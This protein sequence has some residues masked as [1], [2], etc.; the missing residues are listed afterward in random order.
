MNKKKILIFI[1][2]LFSVAFILRLGVA[3][4]MGVNHPME[5][6]AF[7]YLQLA[8][9]LVQGTGY[10]VHDSFWPDQPTMQRMP[11]WPFL[12]SV[13]LRV[14]PWFSPDFV[15]RILCILMDSLNAVL[16]GWLTWRLLWTKVSP[17][18]EARVVAAVSAAPSPV[19]VHDSPGAERK[20]AAGDSRYYTEEAMP[21][22]VSLLAGLIY[23]A[24][25]A[26]L[27]LVYNGESEPLFIMLCLSG[28][29]LLLR[30]GRWV[31]LASLCFGLSC[32]IRANYV[33]WLGVVGGFVVMRWLWAKSAAEDPST[34]FKAGSRSY[35]KREDNRSEA[36]VVAGVPTGTCEKS[37]A[38]TAATTAGK[39]GGMEHGVSTHGRLIPMV[40]LSLLFLAPSLFW[41]TRNYQVCGHFPVLSTLRGQ[42]FYG[43]NNSVVANTMDLWGYWIFPDGVPGEKKAAELA[44]TMTEY[45]LDVYYFNKGKEYVK[46][47]WFAIPRLLLGKF[48]RA[49]VPIPWKPNILSYGVGAYRVVIY[50]LAIAG[51]IWWWRGQREDNGSEARVVTAE[52]G[53]YAESQ[54]KVYGLKAMVSLVFLSMLLTN[55]AGVLIFWGCFRF[56][57]V[58][59]PILI[60]FA[61]MGG[62][63][64]IKEKREES[65]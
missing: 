29:I 17:G 63:W 50:L 4:K 26:A 49:Y 61:V 27:F 39:I 22:V 23:A 16:V 15:M 46:A 40:F 13:G 34:K 21:F 12:V 2:I 1:I 3:F 37:V 43:G 6:D 10:A 5:S 8:K 65:F 36:R 41:A 48:V 47:E 31:Y 45:E 56:A 53:R 25:P 44:K 11:G 64:L 24:H 52:D 58:L 35:T 62:V 19:V 51:I 20:S 32:L 30:G 60:P 54:S 59:E 9:S 42:T 38:E 57:F 33:I 28:F 18:S 14:C 55:L 7:Y